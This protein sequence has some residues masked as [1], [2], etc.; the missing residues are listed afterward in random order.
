MM[1]TTSSQRRDDVVIV[2]VMTMTTMMTSSRRRHR[3]HRHNVVTTCHYRHR[4][5]H[6]VVTTT[7]TTMTVLNA[8]LKT[9]IFCHRYLTPLSSIFF[10][11]IWQFFHRIILKQVFIISWGYI[12]IWHYYCTLSRRG[13]LLYPRTECIFTANS[14][15]AIIPVILTVSWTRMRRIPPYISLR[16]TAFTRTPWEEGKKREGWKPFT[17][18]HDGPTHEYLYSS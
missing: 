9:E 2:V 5:C 7:M 10:H 14:P 17:E 4:R 11:G 6:D 12:Q 13:V 1:T 8:V 16:N 3:R 15:Y 18:L